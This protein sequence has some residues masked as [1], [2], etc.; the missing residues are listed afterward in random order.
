MYTTPI[1]TIQANTSLGWPPP[2]PL[3]CEQYRIGLVVNIIARGSMARPYQ[4]AL[5][6]QNYKKDVYPNVHVR[7][8]QAVCKKM[9]KPYKNS[10]LMHLAT[11]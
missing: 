10:S 4:S 5:K 11:H 8:F 2:I 9:E 1:I 7:M 3:N 6:Y